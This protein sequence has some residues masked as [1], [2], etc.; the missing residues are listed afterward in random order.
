MGG[1]ILSKEISDYYDRNPFGAGLTYNAHP[2][3]V[4]AAIA[5]IGEYM[6]LGTREHVLEL[7]PVLNKYLNE[8][9]QNHPSIGDV[10][11]IGLHGAVEFS[12][13][14]NKRVPIQETADGRH[15]NTVFLNH[16]KEEYGLLTF[17][18]GSHFLTS[19][20]IITTEAELGEIFE[21]LDKACF[22]ADRLVEEIKEAY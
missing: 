12:L 10:R 16:L 2:L 20:P 22:F 8:L 5:C 4:A 11:S 13:D 9:K 3:G 7:E 15:F 1:V 14:R 18:G 17:G 6:R 19:P 21:R